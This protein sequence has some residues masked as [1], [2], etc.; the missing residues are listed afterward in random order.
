[1]KKLLPMATNIAKRMRVSFICQ[2]KYYKPLLI[3]CIYSQARV[4]L[5]RNLFE[6]FITVGVISISPNCTVALN[7]GIQIPIP[8]STDLFMLLNDSLLLLIVPSTYE[9]GL[10]PYGLRTWCR[11]VMSNPRTFRYIS[12]RLSFQRLWNLSFGRTLLPY[13][14]PRKYEWTNISAW[15]I[16]WNFLRCIL[17]L[18]NHSSRTGSMPN[19]NF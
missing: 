14:T 5:I 4:T 15:P 17:N 11:R 10:I 7:L 13:K 8:M 18:P 12:A 6:G 3:Y 1:M 9:K 19:V 2:Q 16:R